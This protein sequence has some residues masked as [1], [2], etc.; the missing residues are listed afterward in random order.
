VARV[1]EF[2]VYTAARFAVFAA[3]VLVAFGVFWLAS[4]GEDVPVLWP[5]LLGAVLSVTVSAWLLRGLREDFATKVQ[6]RAERQ[7]TA[8]HPQPH[9]AEE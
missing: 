4:G 2:L 6:A 5:L 3:C 9:S 7:A 8:R 1:K